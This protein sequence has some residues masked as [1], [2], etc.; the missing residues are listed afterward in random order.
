MQA[1]IEKGWDVAAFF[2]DNFSEEQVHFNVESKIWTSQSD[3]GMRYP[4]TNGGFETKGAPNTSAAVLLREALEEVMSDCQ[5]GVQLRIVGHSMG[6]QMALRASYLLAERVEEGLAPQRYLP[7]RIALLDPYWSPKGPV[8]QWPLSNSQEWLG[9]VEET[10]SSEHVSTASLSLEFA[11][12]LAERFGILF[13]IYTSC[14]WLT[15]YPLGDANPVGELVTRGHAAVVHLRPNFCH[16]LD[17]PGRHLSALGMYLWSMTFDPIRL[18][19]VDGASVSTGTPSAAMS[20][21]QLKLARGSEWVEAWEEKPGH[22]YNP[23]TVSF[24]HH[25]M[26]PSQEPSTLRSARSVARSWTHLGKLQDAGDDPAT[27]L[28]RIAS[29]PAAAALAQTSSTMKGVFFAAGAG[30]FLGIGSV[31]LA[32]FCA[33]S[34]RCAWGTSPRAEPL[35]VACV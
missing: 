7:S 6:S 1:W 24:K 3:V 15:H 34:Q 8:Q 11:G 16:V 19:P 20:D 9:K 28:P 32:V 12:F 4:S 5:D 29:V 21:R 10:Q 2:W 27:A 35:L 14:H 17:W 25:E 30:L 26:K 33:R 22:D 18:T 31:A 23:T 13:E